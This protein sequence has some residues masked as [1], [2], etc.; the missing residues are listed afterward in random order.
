MCSQSMIIITLNL[1]NICSSQ[2]SQN[3]WILSFN[4]H[5]SIFIRQY[6]RIGTLNEYNVKF[7]ENLCPRLY[8]KNLFMLIFFWEPI[9]YSLFSQGS[10]VTK[11]DVGDILGVLFLNNANSCC[12]HCLSQPE[13]IELYNPNFKNIE[14][15]KNKSK[16]QSWFCGIFCWR[17]LWD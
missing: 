5:A 16:L 14:R 12:F 1:S 7:Y 11:R 15:S 9:W 6:H 4:R 17:N 13:L 10:Q 3:Y 8:R 2:Q